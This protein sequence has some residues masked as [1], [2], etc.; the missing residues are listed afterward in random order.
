MVPVTQHW[1]QS[2]PHLNA[3]KETLPLGKIEQC[4]KRMTNEG[5]KE[6]GVREGREEKEPIL[7]IQILSKET[8]QDNETLKSYGTLVLTPD[9]SPVQ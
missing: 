8:L 4:L 7:E 5:E 9:V 3:D 6:E 2:Q 1:A